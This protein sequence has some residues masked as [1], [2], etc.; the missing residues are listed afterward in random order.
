VVWGASGSGVGARE[1]VS[2]DVGADADV[3]AAA[4]AGVGVK[5]EDA[6]PSSQQ[7]QVENS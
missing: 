5:D 6:Y 7:N 3:G 1:G 2:A 4:D